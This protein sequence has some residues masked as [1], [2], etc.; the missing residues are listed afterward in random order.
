MT[1]MIKKPMSKEI[2]WHDIQSLINK[3]DS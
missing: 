3:I 1:D 2:L